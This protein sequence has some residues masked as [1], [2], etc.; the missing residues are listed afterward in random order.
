MVAP[1]T[2][3]F[4]VPL[5]MLLPL[6][7]WYGDLLDRLKIVALRLRPIVEVETDFLVEDMVTALLVSPGS[8]GQLKGAGFGRR[9]MVGSHTAAIL[10]DR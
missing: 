9:S 5:R 2:T 8:M 4:V 7:L 1:A 3:F 6:D 10:V